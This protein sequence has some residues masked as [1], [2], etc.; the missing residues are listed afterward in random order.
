MDRLHARYPFLAAAR[1]AVEEADV[2]LGALVAREGSLGEAVVERAVDRVES[3]I[4]SGTVGEPRRQPAVE[5]LSYPVARVLVSLVGRTELVDV[6]AASE[7]ETARRR[8]ETDVDDDLVAGSAIGLDRLLAEFDLGGVVTPIE[9]PG[10]D[11]FRVDVG[12]YLELAAELEDSA[13]RLAGRD[14][15]AGRVSV[16]R[17]ELYDLL[18]EAIRDR[19]GTDLPVSV[20]EPVGTALDD[21]VDRIQSALADYDLPRADAFDIVAPELFPPCV[22]RLLE[23][24]R[25]GEDLPEHSAFALSAFLAG[26][27]LDTEAV[28]ALSETATGDPED[29]GTLA[30]RLDR[31][32]DGS[33]VDYPPPSC[34]AMDAYGDCVNTDEVCAEVAHP[35][36]YYERRTDAAGSATDYRDRSEV[37]VD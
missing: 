25:D 29:P 14:L 27:G 15:A 22:E 19:V 31:I 32:A 30:Y 33:G 28:A 21:E 17:T 37:D 2:S 24:V 23:R 1:E 36:S 6:Y 13:W 16:S 12:P 20:P 18:G 34:A 35:L 10:E 8:F 3:A 9:R 5:L 11:R 26:V 4:A 7:A